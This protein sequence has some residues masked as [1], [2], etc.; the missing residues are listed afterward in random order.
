MHTRDYTFRYPDS[1]SCQVNA[2]LI[3]K[4]FPAKQKP[5]PQYVGVRACVWDQ[6]YT[7]FA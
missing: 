4:S 3:Q 5:C 2:A 6:H 1:Y 7:G